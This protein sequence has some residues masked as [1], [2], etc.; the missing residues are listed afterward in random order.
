M[1]T[2]EQIL[3]LIIGL[4]I[5]IF[6]IFLI[7]WPII[8]WGHIKKQTGLLEKISQ[9]ISESKVNL[10]VIREELQAQIRPSTASP[11]Q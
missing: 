11:K 10:I 6:A 3:V 7:L 1:G 5:F 2:S 4:G 8:I 9:N